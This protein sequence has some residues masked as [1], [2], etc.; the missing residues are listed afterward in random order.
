M[1]NKKVTMQDIA[2][3]CG[4]SRNTVSKAF[5]GRGS[6][7]RATVDLIVKKAE[8]LGYGSPAAHVLPAGSLSGSASGTIALLTCQMPG[9]THFGMDMITAFTNQISRAGYTLRVFEI[10]AAEQQQI[11]LP[12][13]FMTNQ[14]AGIVCMEVFDAQYLKMVCGLGLPTV[15]IDTPAR[16]ETSII[17]CDVVC[18][19]NIASMAAV[20]RHLN[21]S[22]ARRIGFVGDIEHCGSFFE[23]W[24]GY[25]FELERAGLPFDRDLC[26]LAPDES[27]YDDSDWLAS[28]LQKMLQL[29]DAFVCANDFLAIHLIG[30]LRKLGLSVPEDVMVTGFD[31]TPESALVEPSLTTVQIPSAAI[32][33]LSADILLNRMKNVNRPPFQAYVRTVP[34]WRGS[35]KAKC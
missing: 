9:E 28:Q 34:I 1:P 19:E 30:A 6:V 5:N 27:P 16:A 22:G 23:R 20:V 4:L 10:S 11:T 7:P 15:L 35:T 32:G 18:M 24:Q 17:D 21:G 3:A 25:R 13:H 12:P 2:D 33:Q 26:I 29:P 8:E 31:G 14:T